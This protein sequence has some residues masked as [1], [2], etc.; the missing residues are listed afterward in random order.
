[1]E[2]EKPNTDIKTRIKK[3]TEA[4]KKEKEKQAKVKK[5]TISYKICNI[6]H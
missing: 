5:K 1:M 2:Q 3:V 6:L 4:K